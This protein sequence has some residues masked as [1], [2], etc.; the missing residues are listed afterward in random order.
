MEDGSTV[1][2]CVKS[3]AAF[4]YKFCVGILYI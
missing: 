4:G 2:N 1:G 3:P